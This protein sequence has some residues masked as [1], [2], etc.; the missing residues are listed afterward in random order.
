M[1]PGE[2]ATHRATAR[3]VHPNTWLSMT[4]HVGPVLQHRRCLGVTR[5]SQVGTFEHGLA[6]TAM[7]EI[8]CN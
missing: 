3:S 1:T 7:Y 2:L 5:V 8:C 6:L 4:D